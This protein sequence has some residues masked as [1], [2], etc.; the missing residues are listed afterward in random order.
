MIS[1]GTKVKILCENVEYPLGV[2]V[3]LSSEGFFQQKIV[4]VFFVEL[5]D[6]RK[7]QVAESLLAIS[8]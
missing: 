5:E 1:V 7:I 2:V 3:A 4:K 6:K 8:D